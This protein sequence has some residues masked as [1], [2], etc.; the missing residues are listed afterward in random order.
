MKNMES[1]LTI[2][3]ALILVVTLGYGAWWLYDCFY[4]PW[5]DVPVEAG[6]EPPRPKTY[7]VMPEDSLWAIAVKYYPDHHTG[8]AVHE[9]REL[10]GMMQSATIYPYEVLQLP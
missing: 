2:A 9:I 5:L 8:E 7:Q 6:P 1:V 10:N 4:G 3:L